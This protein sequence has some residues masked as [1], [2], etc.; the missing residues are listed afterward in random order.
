MLHV[1]FVKKCSG[2]VSSRGSKVRGPRYDP[3]QGSK[4]QSCQNQNLIADLDSSQ[5]SSKRK[6]SSF[7]S[8]LILSGSKLG[9]KVTSD[10]NLTSR[11]VKNENADN[12]NSGT[13]FGILINNGLI[14]ITVNFRFSQKMSVKKI[15]PY[16]LIFTLVKKCLGSVSSRGSKVRGSKYDPPRGSKFQSFKN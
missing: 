13:S 1:C 5:K 10:P 4:F 2:S 15:L 6:Y 8:F 3:P 12:Q 14:V 11:E 16:S 9:S 7:F